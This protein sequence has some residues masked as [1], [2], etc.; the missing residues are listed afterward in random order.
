MGA[1]RGIFLKMK[2]YHFTS[3]LHV[4]GCKKEGVYKGVIPLY[5][6][7]NLGVLSGWQWLTANPDFNQGWANTEFSILPYD[8]TAFRIEIV[9]PKTARKRLYKWLDI[10]SRFPIDQHLNTYGDP[11][12]WY[13]FDGRIKPG[14]IRQIRPKD[15]TKISLRED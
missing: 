5:Q 7:G 8:R 13:V 6:N 4:D 12:N 10:C 9:I 15:I 2:L 14:W 1:G 11:K 3:P